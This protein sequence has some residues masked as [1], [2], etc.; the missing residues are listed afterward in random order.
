MALAALKRYFTQ[1]TE[2][3]QGWLEEFKQDYKYTPDIRTLEMGRTWFVFEYGE[4]MEGRFEHETFMETGKV[5]KVGCA[6]TR[7]SNLVMYKKNLGSFSYPVI[8]SYMP[9]HP[10]KQYRIKQE[11]EPGRIKGDLFLVQGAQSI[12]ELD[13]ARE[14]GVAFKRV[15]MN[16]L[17]PYIHTVWD[18]KTGSFASTEYLEETPAWVYIGVKTYWDNLIDGGYSSSLVRRFKH[19]T[20]RREYAEYPMGDYYYYSALEDDD[21]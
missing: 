3:P 2:L 13:R 9:N 21:K 10:K 14:N 1:E 16:V 5:Q 20:N 17:F 6:F 11:G 12:V 19:V 8:L 18:E 7:F 15:R 4:C